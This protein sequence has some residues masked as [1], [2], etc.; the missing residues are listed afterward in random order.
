MKRGG[1][2]SSPLERN[3]EL[4]ARVA[5]VSLVA[6]LGLKSHTTVNHIHSVWDPCDVWV[7]MNYCSYVTTQGLQI[8]TFT[9]IVSKH[10]GSW[11]R[12]KWSESHCSTAVKLFMWRHVFHL[13]DAFSF[14]SFI[15]DRRL[16]SKKGL[17]FQKPPL[18]TDTVALGVKIL[19]VCTAHISA[20]P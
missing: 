2:F 14:T 12:S 7:C 3:S 10:K 16:W 15:S 20:Q 6:L 9:N 17:I 13:P 5:S 19:V 11:M 18:I 1:F 4:S 8:A